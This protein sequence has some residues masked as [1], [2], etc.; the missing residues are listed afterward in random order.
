MRGFPFKLVP[1]FA[2]L[3]M[4]TPG[5]LTAEGFKPGE[6]WL[7][8]E[9]N[10]IQAHG[11][12]IL[13][14][15]NTYYWYGEDRTPG[16]PGG[17][18][19]YSS[20]NLH[21]WKRE[22]LVLSHPTLREATS[23]RTFIE[24][25]KVIFNDKTGKYV[26]W[27]HAEQRGY[28][29]ARA[30]IAISDTPA[31]QFEFLDAIRPVQFDFGYKEDDPDQQAEFGGTFRDMNLFVDA[32]GRAYVLYASEHNATLYVVRLNEEFTGPELPMVKGKT[33]E[34]VLV[35]KYR[36][37]PAP[38][39]HEG[40]YHL[41]TSGCTGWAPNAADHAVADNILGPWEQKGNPCVGPESEL[42]FRSQSTFVLPVQGRPGAFILMADRWKPRELSDS[43]YIWLPF[44]VKDDH[45]I[46]IQWRDSWNLSVFDAD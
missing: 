36:E 28:H 24:R 33:W 45:S 27:F 1:L 12:G 16:G 46:S 4:T 13:V 5:T 18:A 14:R 39:K 2:L 9:G 34:R 35:G 29:Y 37:A 22:G 38:F 44:E 43:R 10:P 19:C 41:I 11:G 26:M 30:G 15:G 32:D 17:V 21:D 42:T 3:T 40:R 7:D 23:G 31:G 8:T 6:V 25:P 20:T